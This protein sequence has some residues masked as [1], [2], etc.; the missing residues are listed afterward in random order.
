MLCTVSPRA[1]PSIRA[2]SMGLVQPG[3]DLIM[4]LTE[5]PMVEAHR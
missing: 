2:L 4:E 5:S 3:S 1:N